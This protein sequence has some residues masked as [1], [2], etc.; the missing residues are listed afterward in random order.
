MYTVTRFFFICFCLLHANAQAQAHALPT[1][2]IG[3]ASTIC[4]IRFFQSYFRVIY[5]YFGY[6][7]WIFFVQ[8]LQF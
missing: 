2:K 3:S 5:N 7:F 1:G 8:N 6:S 4:V